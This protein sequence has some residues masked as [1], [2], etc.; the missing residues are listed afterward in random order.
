M[1]KIILLGPEV[2]LET[3]EKIALIQENIQVTQSRQEK[4]ADKRRMMLE[5]KLGDLVFFSIQEGTP[6]VR[7]A[8]DLKSSNSLL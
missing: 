3:T 1:G 6:K 2:L 4:Y 8:S 7:Q 5:F